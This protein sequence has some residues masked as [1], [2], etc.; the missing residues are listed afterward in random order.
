MRIEGYSQP[1]LTKEDMEFGKKF[2]ERPKDEEKPKP[3][4]KPEDIRF[5]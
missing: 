4:P 2:E 5:Y 1:A 3:E